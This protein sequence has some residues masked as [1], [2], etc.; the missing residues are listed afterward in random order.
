MPADST[1]R[2]RIDSI[3]KEKAAKAL[4]DMGLSLSDAIRLLMVR[5][6]AEKSLPF[7]VKKPN[8]VTRKA[9]KELDQ[10]KGR[11]FADVA[12]LMEDLD[13]DY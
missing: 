6:A 9:M 1:V 12:A 4:Q 7:P 13:A 3:T 5:V 10:G 8:A 2:A 11:R